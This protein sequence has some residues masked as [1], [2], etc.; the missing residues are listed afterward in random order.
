MSFDYYLRSGDKKLRCGY[1][2]G[3][4]AALASSG[5]AMRL[6]GGIVPEDVS[7]M[8][9]K[10]IVV[11]VPVFACEGNGQRAWCSVIK[12][13]GDDAD[14]TDGME[15][16]AEVSLSDEEDISIEG[17]SGVGRVTRP[18]LDQP[19]GSAAIN[20]VPRQM[21][22][23][24]VS[25]VCDMYGY[26]GGIKVIIS[27]PEGEA[28]A[29]KTFNPML[30]VKGGLSILGT[31]GIVEPMSQQAL[32]DTVEVS[33]R[34]AAAASKALILTPGNYGER[35]IEE[36]DIDR[37]GIPVVKCS[38]FIG[39]A[40]DMAAAEGF[41]TVLLIGH[42]GKLVKTAGGVMNTHSRYADCRQEIIC[43]HAAVCGGSG[44]LCRSLMEA[45]TTDACIELLDGA[46]LREAVLES[47]MTAI[48]HHLGRRAGGAYETGAVMFSNRYGILGYTKTAEQILSKWKAG[49]R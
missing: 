22:T 49:K 48:Q 27:I 15:I 26:E 36:E 40:L 23:Q 21:I 19:V 43:A 31:S 1:T 29:A 18:G 8:T 7:V 24:A 30:G 45:A 41:E 37:Y 46:G 39:D 35:F 17:G 28:A 2:T 9:G 4:C 16:R 25:D 13:A 12:D 32:I 14:I 10:G 34:Q 38:N 11:K 3:T 42:I 6:L 33:V 20:S 5:A 47:I 44:E